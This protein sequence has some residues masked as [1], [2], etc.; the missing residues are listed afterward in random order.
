[1]ERL[2]RAMSN[3][4][5]RALFPEG[6]V[7]TLPRTYLDHSPLVVLTQGMHPSNPLNRPFR[8]EAAWFCHS[9]FIDVVQN[10]WL[11]RS[12]NLLE[13]N[14]SFTD[15]VKIWNKKVFG[16]IFKR[17]RTLLARIEGIQ[18]AQVLAFSHNL[19]FLEK[20][21]INQYNNTV[22]QEEILWFQKSRSKWLTLGDKNTR[23]F[24]ISTLVKRRKLKIN[25]LKDEEGNWISS[26][27]ELK[28]HIIDH[29]INLF[30]FEETTIVEGTNSK[31]VTKPY[32]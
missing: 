32:I 31:T 9:N 5:W 22:F 29:F 30:K 7:R 20:D 12:H 11:N 1:M 14:N 18:K 26:M 2:D 24:H 21:L 13:A 4:R 17:K 8:C 19:H 10:S 25:V 27:N 3:D 6:T 23:Y 28:A 15:N 16:N